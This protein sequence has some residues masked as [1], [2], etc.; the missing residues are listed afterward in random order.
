MVAG[1]WLTPAIVCLV[2]LIAATWSVPA[3]SHVGPAEWVMG[4][5]LA[6]GFLYRVIRVDPAASRQFDRDGPLWRMA[7]LGGLMLAVVPAMAGAV[8]GHEV[9]FMARDLVGHALLL[10][11]LWMLAPGNPGEIRLSGWRALSSL[12]IVGWSLACAGLIVSLRALGDSGMGWSDIGQVFANHRERYLA[13]SVFIPFAALFLLGW[14]MAALAR[15]GWR[16]AA[17]GVVGIAV[18]ALP[19]AV[20]LL[21]GHRGLTLGLILGGLWLMALHP[22]RVRARVLVIIAGIVTLTGLAGGGAGA[23]IT[24]LWEKSLAVGL[25]NRFDEV[26]LVISSLGNDPVALTVGFGWGAVFLSPAVG[27][28]AVTF[29]HNLPFYLLLKGGVLALV[30]I[31]PYAVLI[32]I[33]ARRAVVFAPGLTIASVIPLANGVLFHTSFKSL[34]F[35]ILLCCLALTAMAARDAG[36]PKIR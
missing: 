36:N 20:I 11:P 25:N 21:S 2:A 24:L 19:S 33:W 1:L 22:G 27:E 34:G 18:A 6:L 30:A 15:E 14:A 7:A 23:A 29:V 9:P 31:T 5:L 26:A 8:R 4:V 10:M 13:N 3:P 28:M 12:A 32:V 35:G 16:H 17:A